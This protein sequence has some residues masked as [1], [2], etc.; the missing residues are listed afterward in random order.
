MP[1][2]VIEVALPT[3]LRRTFDYLP[4]PETERC[5]YQCGQRIRVRFGTRTLIG[6]VLAT[7]S[8]S[9]IAP[10]KLRPVLDII[11]AT[12][13]IDATSM[14]LYRWLAQYYHHSLGDVLDNALPT[15]LRKGE[16]LSCVEERVWRR[17]AAPDTDT[18]ALKGAKQKALW[19]AFL[20]HT[21]YTHRE[22]RRQGFSLAQLRALSELH[23]INESTALM[24]PSVDTHHTPPLTLNTEQ[25]LA[26][27]AIQNTLGSYHTCL[28]EGVTGSGKTEVYLQLIQAVLERG[29]QVLVLVPEIGLTPQTV[30]RFKTRFE[31][32]IALLH[33]GLQ[34]KERLHAWRC[35]RE[36]RAPIVIGTRSAVFTPLPKLGL[37][38]VDEEHDA[39]FKQQDGMRYHARDFALVRAKKQN[40][41]VVLGS[42]T[43]SLETLNNAL[44]GRYL[45]AR[46]QTRAGKAKPPLMALYNSLNQ[47]QTAGFVHP[48]LDKIH[49]HLERG[50]QVL[51]FMNRRGFSPMLSCPTCGWLSQCTQCDAR[52]TLHQYPPRLHCHH[53]DA[54][55]SIP[56]HCPKCGHHT[57]EAL[58]QGTE[59]IEQ[60]L[61]ELFPD[62][63]VLRIDRDTMSTKHAFD[64]AL[65]T[66][67]TGEP[68][69]LVGTQMLAKGHHFPNVSL[70]VV[71]DSDGGLFSADFR[72]M[73]H[74]AQLLLQVAGRAGREEIE[75][76]V[77][78]QTRYA[79]HPQLNEL[80]HNGYHALALELLKEREQRQLPPYHHLALLRTDA[81]NQTHAMDLA[82]QARSFVQQWLAGRFQGSTPITLLGPFA[83]MMER[84]AGRFRQQLQIHATA[85]APLHQL[86]EALAHF[87]EG[88]PKP[89]DARWH[90]DVDPTDTL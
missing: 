51:V 19:Q 57:L 58:G 49:S 2:F 56:K 21:Q 78:I 10:E 85:R 86:L 54:K 5:D 1:P 26:L 44:S 84:R 14:S 40:A 8:A 36:E 62:V 52:M 16:H 29:Q 80:I 76:E 83:A 79:D 28:L 90:I 3:P 46:L 60:Q 15:L 70:V 31:C 20:A 89:K 17:Y 69:L 41:V 18:H 9:D 72:G 55:Q 45:H 22:L 47:P 12:P 82:N 23:L 48:V 64:D 37:I 38:I 30:Q 11:D 74:A 42:A 32:P 53:C 61:G 33:S 43:P 25:S 50:Q 4:K 88:S 81:V 73:E 67:H 39:S 13:I 24:A 66:I 68:C 87:L 6:L 77:C 71:P 7:K 59:R 35:A 75:G 34:D 63:P 65:A 27:D